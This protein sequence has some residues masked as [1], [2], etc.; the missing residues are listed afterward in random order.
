MILPF[1]AQATSVILIERFYR[2]V[3]YE[4]GSVR[5]TWLESVSGPVRQPGPTKSCQSLPLGNE[6]RWPLRNQIIVP[7]ALVMLGTLAGASVLN[8]WLSARRV[9]AQIERQLRDVTRTSADSNFRLTDPILRQMQGLSGAEF[10]LMDDSNVILASSM[11]KDV[12]SQLPLQEPTDQWSQLTLGDAIRIDDGRYFHAAVRMQRRSVP[13]QD[14]VLH[15]LYP[16]QSYREAWLGAVFP[17]LVVG[18]AA[19]VL[20]VVLAAVIASRVSRPLAR[21]RGQVEHIAEG[22]FQPL[23]LPGRDDE[24]LDLAKSINRMANMLARYEEEVRTNERLRTLGQLGSGMA[25]QMRN[26][27][28][29]CRM[30]LDLHRRE[31]PSESDSES[32]DVAARQ[33]ALMEKYLQRFLSLGHASPKPHEQVDLTQLVDNVLP[34]VR[35]AARHVGVELQWAGSDKPCIIQGDVDALEQL[36]V[37]LLLNAIEA[38]TQADERRVSASVSPSSAG[39]VTMEIFDSGKGPAPEIQDTLFDPFV[40]NKADGTGLGLS[41]A[42]EIAEQHG[43]KIGWERREGMTC[44]VVDFPAEGP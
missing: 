1:V 42:N 38:A 43:G 41:V 8:A 30:A 35:P 21:L 5:K 23:P 28:T 14:G 33:L 36:A 37:N 34:L 6:M 7:M 4:I 16:E 31:C 13:S 27:A 40:T 2:R 24:V 18:G 39:G 26:S 44:F 12:L 20:V 3:Y 29:G 9:R 17:P 32:L 22:D 19:L 10:V 15:I 11:P 25:H